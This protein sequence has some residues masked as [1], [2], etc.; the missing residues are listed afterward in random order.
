MIKMNSTQPIY[1]KINYNLIVSYDLDNNIIFYQ[2]R[3]VIPTERLP[4][5]LSKIGGE[6]SLF[7]VN[8]VDPD[9]DSLFIYNGIHRNEIKTREE[10]P[11]LLKKYNVK[12]NFFQKELKW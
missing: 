8:K 10:L 5:Y 2:S 1:P 4:K 3:T 7:N 11:T 6:K 12:T 9:I